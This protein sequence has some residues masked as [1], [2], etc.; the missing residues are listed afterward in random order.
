MNNKKFNNLFTGLM[1]QLK[2]YL[3]CFILVIAIRVLILY[4]NYKYINPYNVPYYGQGQGQCFF[5]NPD[6]L[7]LYPILINNL[8]D[9]FNWIW[10]IIKMI[11][12]TKFW[13]LNQTILCQSL[14]TETVEFI[15]VDRI[16]LSLI[17]ERH[18]GEGWKNVLVKIIRA[19]AT[20]P[21]RHEL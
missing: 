19:L 18:L 15:S 17:E 10:E 3:V 4:L 21:L 2:M 12:Y 20:Q 7:W 13:G 14:D 5:L 8:V 6:S 1:K 9:C 11:F 16:Y